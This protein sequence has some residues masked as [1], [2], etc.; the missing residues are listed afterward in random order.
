MLNQLIALIGA[1]SVLSAYLGIPVA[2]IYRWR[3]LGQGP[4]GIRVGRHVRFRLADVERWLD[5][6]ADRPKGA[7]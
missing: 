6:Q 2:S 3:Y 4:R 1:I 5:E 7:A